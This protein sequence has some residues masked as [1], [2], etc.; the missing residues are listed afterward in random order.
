MVRGGCNDIYDSIPWE[1]G[2]IH[3]IALET[4]KH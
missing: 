1:N 3:Y 4:P 2:K